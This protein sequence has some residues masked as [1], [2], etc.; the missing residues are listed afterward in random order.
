MNLKE[1][2]GETAKGM[3]LDAALAL[4]GE[5][6]RSKA[7]KLIE[8]GRVLVGGRERKCNYKVGNKDVISCEIPDVESYDAVAEDIPIDIIYQDRDLAVINKAKGM[9]VHPAP[10]HYSGTLVNA[11][12]YHIK[13]LSGIGGVQRPGIV[14]RLD[15]DTSG[16][17]VIAKNDEAHEGLSA[18]LENKSMNRRYLAVCKGNF[19]DEFF[20]VEKPIGRSKKD[21]KKMCVC[22]EGEGRYAKTA[23][24]VLSQSEGYS[25]LEC[26]LFTG[27]THQIRV[28]LSHVGHPIVGDEV[29]GKKG[30]I[31]FSGQALHGYRLEFKHPLSGEQMVFTVK[32]PE[33][34]VCLAAKLKLT[35]PCEHKLL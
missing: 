20:E 2:N 27:R 14:H 7:Q 19:K 11:I 15:K 21:R 6:S 17:L 12:M 4:L 13:D 16:L 24:R 29:Y 18:Q 34:F 32:P 26:C 35:L 33:D 28:H 30:K 31:N 9:V 8:E 1:Y 23:F 22:H 10:G 25:L 3:R 5:M